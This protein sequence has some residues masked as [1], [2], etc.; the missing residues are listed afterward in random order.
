M[1]EHE[2]FVENRRRA[3]RKFAVGVV[4]AA[5]P[6][7]GKSLVRRLSDSAPSSGFFRR[8]RFGAFRAGMRESGYVEGKNLII[9][10]RFAD[11]K[12]ERLAGWLRKLCN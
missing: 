6:N 4:R 2:E 5:R 7:P 9:G 8:Q 3:G 11:G 1:V 12:P 10:W